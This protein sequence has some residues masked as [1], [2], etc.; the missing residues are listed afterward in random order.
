M[1][2]EYRTSDLGEAATLNAAGFRVSK[3]DKS[4]PKRVVFLF[5][6]STELKQCVEGY[7]SGDYKLSANLIIDSIKL[8]KALIYE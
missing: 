7:W 4:N 6:N 2:D 1:V 8:L 3:V 5:V